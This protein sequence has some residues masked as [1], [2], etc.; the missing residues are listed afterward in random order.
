MIT[1]LGQNQVLV[2]NFKISAQKLNVKFEAQ[3]F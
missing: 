2:E 1:T 3:K